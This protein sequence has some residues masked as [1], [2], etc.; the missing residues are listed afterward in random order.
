MQQ[1]I[2]NG[3]AKPVFKGL[4]HSGE[5]YNEAIDCL[6]S[7]FN[8]PRLLHHAQVRKIVEATSLKDGSG[9]ELRRLHD[10]VQQHLRALKAMGSEPDE[11]FITSVIELKLDVD[12]MFEWQRHSQDKTEVPS[13]SEILKTSLSSSSKKPPAKKPFTPVTTFTAN[14]KSM[15]NCI[16]CNVEWHPLHIYPKFKVMS[17]SDKMSTLRKSNFCINCL[18][19]RHTVKDC[20]S[21]HRCKRCQHPHHTLLHI[22]LNHLSTSAPP[23]PTSLQVSANSGIRIQSSS[24]L[25]TCRVLIKARDESF[26]EGRALLDNASSASFISECPSQNLQ[27]PCSPQTIHIFGIAGSSTPRSPIQSVAS[28][29]ITPL[30]GDSSKQIDLT[31]IVLLKVTCDLPV[32]SVPFD[33]SWS[34]ISDLSLADPAF[35]L[36]GHIDLLLGADIFVSVL[37]QG[38]RMGPPGAPVA[39][40]TEV[41]WVLSGNTEPIMEAEQVNLYVTT[42]HS[43]TSSCDDILKRFCEIE[44]SPSAKPALT[45]ERTVVKHFDTH[46]CRAD[47]GSFVVPLPK[48]S[49]CK[50]LGESRSQAIRRF[51]SLERSLTQRNK[52]HEFQT[53]MRDYMELGHPESVPSIDMYKPPEEVFYLP[54]HA[55]YKESSI[56][57]KVRAV[58]NA[59]AKSSTGVSLNDTL[60]VGP[61]IHPPLIDVLLRFRSP[62]IALT[63]DVSK[64][65]RAIKL[66]EEDQNLHC[67]V[68][69]SSPIDKIQDYRMTRVTFGVAASSFAANMAVKQNALDFSYE[70][71][72]AAQTVET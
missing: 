36:P 4:S 9:K 41:G 52:F 59:S 37:R 56:T 60:L 64:M 22:G 72:M 13:Y 29:R 40:E 58:F 51:L 8:R 21:S 7:H 34:H 33:S 69:R 10:T 44:E 70:Y 42:F 14:S 35:G 45:L 11:S 20:K 23:P 49:G 67:F 71:P 28:F 53:V 47:D 2:K 27:L 26:V 39:L 48:R 54:M 55:V 62:H 15:G 16:L 24:L 5:N 6:K 3:S 43:F 17:H 1:A 30:Y 31:A 61:T 25:M 50:S 68:W 38:Q 65:Y 66:I 63:A 32:S 57:T 18:N 19:G 46:H 12:T